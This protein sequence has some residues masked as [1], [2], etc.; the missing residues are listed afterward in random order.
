VS[1]CIAILAV[2]LVGVHSHSLTSADVDTISAAIVSTF[3]LT[4]SYGT[5]CNGAIAPCPLGDN[6][7]ALV[8][9]PFHDAT[10]NGGPNGCIDFEFTSSNDGLQEVVGQLN[11]MYFSNGF[12]QII[13]KADLYV[14][15]GN[16]ATQYASMVPDPPALTTLDKPPHTL[17]LPF[18]YGRVDAFSCNDA[19]W[20]PESDITWDEMFAL[21]GGRFGMSIKEAVAILGAHS[22]GRCP[23]SVCVFVGGWT[24]TQSSFSNEYFKILAQGRFVNNNQSAVWV[25]NET[26]TIMLMVDVESLFVTNSDG[27]GSCNVVDSLEETSKCPF[28]SQSVS[29][30]LDFAVNITRFY[31]KYSSAW[32]KMTELGYTDTMFEVDSTYIGTYPFVTG[33]PSPSAQPTGPTFS[34]TV[35]PTLEP[36]VVGATVA[37]SSMPT[38]MP[39]ELPSPFP[40]SVPTV[41]P[42]YAFVATIH[43]YQ[44]LQGMDAATWYADPNITLSFQEAVAAACE[45][46]ISANDVNVTGVIDGPSLAVMAT[47]KQKHILASSI[48][49]EY[50]VN[51]AMGVVSEALIGNITSALINNVNGGSFSLL[52]KSFGQK[53]GVS[54]LSGGGVTAVANGVSFTVT[55]GVPTNVPTP[56]PTMA[57]GL[58]SSGNDGH[59]T[60]ISTTSIIIIVV[61]VGS[62]ALLA[63]ALAIVRAVL[64]WHTVTAGISAVNTDEAD[65]IE[66]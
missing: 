2:I 13:S 23:Y 42:T 5:F 33:T 53:N 65:F 50:T 37:P 15:A 3:G 61:V 31:K 62:V 1:A 24:D 49:V 60:I 51:R 64:I 25:S 52:L 34:P 41:A 58:T 66:I 56:M 63:S 18:R 45:Y 57:S 29:A 16:V 6:I 27:Q 39:S 19:G 7:G 20:L 44:T 4:P 10:G 17:M 47:H 11:D 9:L 54:S 8:R 38:S 22:G 36:T 30:Y 26:E 12:D 43:V 59:H 28:Q 55:T 46:G 14:L 40:T 32:Q 21:F 35:S 48:I